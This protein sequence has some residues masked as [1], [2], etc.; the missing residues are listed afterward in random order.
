MKSKPKEIEQKQITYIHKISSSFVH[1]ALE[2]YFIQIYMYIKQCAWIYKFKKKIFSCIFL[3]SFTYCLY[4]LYRPDTKNK[5]F[6]IVKYM[7][8]AICMRGLICTKG[9]YFELFVAISIYIEYIYIYTSRIDNNFCT[10]TPEAEYIY[11][12]YIFC[13]VQPKIMLFY[14]RNHLSYNFLNIFSAIYVY[15]CLLRLVYTTFSIEYFLYFINYICILNIII[16]R[17]GNVYLCLKRKHQ[18]SII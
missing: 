10:C 9:W 5:M 6:V 14:L 15:Y 17:R 11:C 1:L 2:L 8:F 16:A 12:V 3:F 13:F 18:E 4:I 7:L